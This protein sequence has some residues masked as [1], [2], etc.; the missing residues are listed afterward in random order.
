MN[1]T[2]MINQIIF[3]V[4]DDKYYINSMTL[5]IFNKMKKTLSANYDMKIIN[6]KH[7][8]N[9]K[10]ISDFYPCVFFVS[11]GEIM[12]KI[13]GFRN[14]NTYLKLLNNKFT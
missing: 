5:A 8:S 11:K 7:L 13:I 1:Q 3:L 9:S 4:Q 6:K 12:N 2:N 14:I 10:Y